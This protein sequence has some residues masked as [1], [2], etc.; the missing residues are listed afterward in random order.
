[1]CL[2]LL[3]SDTFELDFIFAEV[4]FTAKQV[5]IPIKLTVNGMPYSEVYI[6]KQI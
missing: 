3:I 2:P 4:D 6:L 1:M 5:V